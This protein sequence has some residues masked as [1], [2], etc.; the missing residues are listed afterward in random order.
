MAFSVIKKVSCSLVTLYT[1]LA[2][3]ELY[4][5]PHAGW[6]GPASHALCRRQTSFDRKVLDGSLP[7]ISN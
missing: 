5:L 7:S 1:T 3:S 4:N 6:S 2:C